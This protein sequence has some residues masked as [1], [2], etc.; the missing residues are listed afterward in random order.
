MKRTK[1]KKYGLISN[2]WFH[3]QQV[4]KWDKRIF[5]L[6]FL[7][8]IPG[9]IIQG[10]EA[11]LPA[12][13]VRGLQ[14]HWS[15]QKIIVSLLGL[16]LVMGIL[17][18]MGSSSIR[19]L[20]QYGKN[21]DMHYEELCFKKIMAVDYDDLEQ[22]E[23]QK[24]IANVWQ[25][26][27]GSNAICYFAGGWP[28]LLTSMINT[29]VYGF[30]IGQK[31]IIILLFLSVGVC[32]S[33]YLLKL[34]QKVHG[35]KSGEIGGCMKEINYVNREAM[36]RS[37]GKDIR[38][39]HMQNWLLNKYQGAI[40]RLDGI[41]KY[42]HNR[43]LIRSTVDSMVT[44]ITQFISYAYLLSLLVKGQMELDE[45]IFYV[46]LIDVFTSQ[47]ALCIYTSLIMN[48]LSELVRYIREFLDLEEN[49]RWG[50]GI[51]R[52]QLEEIK[53]NGIEIELRHLS[54]TYPGE[55][56]ATLKDINLTIA[57]NE[58][59]ALIGLNGAGKTTFV[60][61]LCGFYAPTEGEIRIN[62][63][64]ATRF[65]KEQYYELVSV[66]FQ[67]SMVVP[68]SLDGNLTGEI[69]SEKIDKSRLNHMLNLSGFITKYESLPYKGATQLVREVN[70]QATDFSGGEMQKF[71]FARALYKKAPL[72]ILDEPTAALDPIAENEMYLKYEAAAKNRTSIYISHRLS[73]T[74]FCDRIILLEDSVIREEGTHEELMEKNGRYAEL[75][76][77]QSQY[78]KEDI[79]C[80]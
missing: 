27:Q 53:K 59:I 12:G 22:K 67:D 47:L 46:T 50:E 13:L 29:L 62:G 54:Y 63:V 32:V 4:R 18:I 56:E 48:P 61:I 68:Q 35:I 21:V 58:R 24:L 69:E 1:T 80:Q 41:S 11:C 14:E 45:F 55:S 37:A 33:F 34:V 7:A 17:L 15:I 78:Y 38:M 9:F 8:V 36:E 70:S 20:Y 39:Y 57:P 25:G 40:K 28:I 23:N 19:I 5:Y 31:N 51:G 52:E 77:L 26:F 2:L 6:E 30:I 65:T 49:R 44:C 60:K 66:L 42:I 10:I 72:L 73:S 71:F 16:G 79:K 76:N 43:Y 64:P 75:Y 74:R 3:M